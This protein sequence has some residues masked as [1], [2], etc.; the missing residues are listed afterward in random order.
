M[1]VEINIIRA[2]STDPDLFVNREE[3]ILK[4]RRLLRLYLKETRPE[5]GRGVL[6]KG[7]SGVGKSILSRKAV[8]ELKTEFSRELVVWG[9]DGGRLTG[10]RGL[11]NKLSDVA[12]DE[13]EKTGNGELTKLA[14]IVA[15][16]ADYGKV[17]ASDVTQISKELSALGKIGSRL[18]GLFTVE[19][20]GGWK[21]TAGKSATEGFEIPIS[22]EY[23]TKLISR[24]LE[25]VAEHGYRVLIFLDNL[26]RI[27]SM[28]SQKDANTIAELVKQLL[29]LPN[30]ILLINLRS[31]FTH[32]T[33]D[34][35]E[36]DHF[37]VKGLAPESLLDI[38]RQRKAAAKLSDD[39]QKKLAAAPLAEVAEK[40]ARLTDNPLA[41]LRWLE[42]WLLR[43]EN[44]IVDL[45]ADF[46]EFIEQ[47]FTGV[48]P[49]WLR[50][51]VKELQD[52]KES[53]L[54]DAPLTSLDKI[55]L[56]KLERAGTIVP[57]SLLV[58]PA[59]RRYRLNHD[60]DFLLAAEFVAAL[61]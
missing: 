28:D 9:V 57:D 27:G 47:N 61:R 10:A 26:D 13:I 35:R 11:L 4:L 41:F 18:L 1:A 38:L 8:A 24:L 50:Q 3:E 6:V 59:D 49:K 37:V 44:R 60:L 33:T 54:Y 5:A 2:T 42:F 51:A 45:A 55:K 15:Q 7:D 46:R 52:A 30:C 20:V 53:G 43:T 23:L 34:R 29:E 14:A 21:H 31:Q 16:A 17:T 12:R 22:E 36:L 25:A 32:H 40:L 19:G 39:E 56:A 48:D 58:D